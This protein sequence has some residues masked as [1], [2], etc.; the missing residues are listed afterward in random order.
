MSDGRVIVVGSLNEDLVL[1]VVSIPRP[2]ETVLADGVSRGCGG[3]GA[4]QA[5]AAARAG[6]A[7]RMVGSVGDD[8]AG[9]RLLR[10]LN[11]DGI[12][13][14]GVRTAAADTGM[15]V[16]SLAADAEN[17]IV[18]APGANGET[19]E[20]T[21]AGGLLDLT[22]RDLVLVQAEIPPIAIEAAAA[23]AAAAGARM[24]LNLAPP[25][26][27]DLALM[28][29]DV[30]MV[31]QHEAAA[32]TEVS[33]IS[34]AARHLA[35]CHDTTVVVTLGADGVIIADPAG[36]TRLPAIPPPR[37]VD[38][39]GAGDA[40]AGAFAAALVRGPTIETAVRWGTAA[41]SLAVAAEGAQ[42]A[43]ATPAAIGALLDSTN[44]A[45]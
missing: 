45:T 26:A 24:V 21:V 43:H 38:T 3:K 41:G 5:V 8:D 2:G 16:V 28:S 39:T 14:T 33:D 10:R 42:G 36:E 29:V 35:A 12:D 17:A 44:H 1:A 19:D 22:D 20:S 31:N 13:T 27:V 25:A 4:N 40:F 30:L 11:A 9:G 18:V 23:R 7:V 15:A 37:I 32:L 6:A 34:A